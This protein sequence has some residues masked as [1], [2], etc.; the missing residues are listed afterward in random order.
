MHNHSDITAVLLAGGLGTRLRSVVSD[1]PKILANICNRP[2]ATFLLEQLMLAGIRDVVLCTGYLADEVYE[3]LGDAYKSLNLTYSKEDIP[4]DTGGA[5]R[6]SLP[7]IKSDTALVMNGDSFVNIKIAVYMDWFFKKKCPASLLLTNVS[8]TRRFGKVL[9]EDGG[10]LFAFEEKGAGSGSGWINAG[11]YLIKKSLIETIPD[12]KPFSLEREF[13]PKLIHQGLYG[14]QFKGEFID[15]GT[16][17]SF[18]LAEDF[19]SLFKV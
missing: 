13:F 1:R 7:Y 19:F 11:I 16:P 4:L 17:E 18:A 5:L 9:V 12:G 14:F 6:L 10:R 2:F 3:E 8:D 15:I